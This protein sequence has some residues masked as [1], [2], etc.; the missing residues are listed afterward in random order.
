MLYI[1]KEDGNNLTEVLKNSVKK[2]SNG[3]GGNE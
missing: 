3:E 2:M 1:T